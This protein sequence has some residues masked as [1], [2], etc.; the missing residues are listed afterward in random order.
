MLLAR[1]LVGVIAL[2]Q[3]LSERS[4]VLVI[5]AVAIDLL[6]LGLFVCIVVLVAADEWDGGTRRQFLRNV[7]RA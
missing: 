2:D 7:R 1:A 6:A 4:A 3:M 5:A